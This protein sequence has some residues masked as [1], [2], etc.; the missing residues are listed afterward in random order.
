M[1]I[2]PTCKEVHRLVSERLDR[3]LT[4]TERA[5]V[6]LHLLACDAC[7][8]FSRQMA[9]IRSAMRQLA[10]LADD[11]TPVTPA[12]APDITPPA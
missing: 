5:R 9:L 11:S 1:G 10:P 6:R 3:N 4:L 8:R 7:T 12:P 2:K